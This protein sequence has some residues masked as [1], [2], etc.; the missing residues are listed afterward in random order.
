MIPSELG[1]SVAANGLNDLKDGESYDLAT[2][3]QTAI[4]VIDQAIKDVSTQRAKLGAIQANVLESNQR[5]LGVAR[6]NM[7]ASESRIRDVDMA[8]EMMEFT[9][10]QILT[11]AATAMLA[12][13]NAVPQGVLQLLR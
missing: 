10:N 7:Q 12:Q 11:Q 2:D 13:A 3:A 8:Q 9:K 6:E 1:A 4:D 5:N